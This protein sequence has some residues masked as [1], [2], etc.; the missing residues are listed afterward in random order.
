MGRYCL[1][2]LMSSDRT[3]HLSLDDYIYIYI[4]ISRERSRTLPN[5]SALWLW[6]RKPRGRLR[7]RSP[8]T[9]VAHNFIYIYIYIYIY[10]EREREREQDFMYLADINERFKH[11]CRFWLVVFLLWFTV[12][13]FV[14]CESF[15]FVFLSLLL[16]VSNTEAEDSE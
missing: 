14:F 13:I 3:K 7:L 9:T 15:C 5:T 8:S 1:A 4:Y 16:I 2:T 12:L 10:I 6:K 11:F